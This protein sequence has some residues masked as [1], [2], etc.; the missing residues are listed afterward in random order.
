MQRGTRNPPH[1]VFQLLSLCSDGDGD[2]RCR[3]FGAWSMS[4]HVFSFAHS[5]NRPASVVI[6]LCCLAT[7]ELQFGCHPDNEETGWEPQGL[8]FGG[9]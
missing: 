8:L 9:R 5:V 1:T 3:A 6:A 7:G 4:L 2:D